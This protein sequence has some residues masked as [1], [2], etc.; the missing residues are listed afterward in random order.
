M[1][2]EAPGALRLGFAGED[3]WRRAIQAVWARAA[4][5]FCYREGRERGG[6]WQGGVK[7][8]VKRRRY[9]ATVQRVRVEDKATGTVGPLVSGC[10]EREERRA[11]E[12]ASLYWPC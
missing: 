1:A 9:G 10:A 7:S 5:R 4:C 6:R 2:Q 11:Y 3:S 8:T 12:R